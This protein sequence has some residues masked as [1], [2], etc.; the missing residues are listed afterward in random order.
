MN[1]T[2][3]IHNVSYGRP[4]SQFGTGNL[5]KGLEGHIIPVVIEHTHVIA[6]RCVFEFTSTAEAIKQLAVR[7]RKLEMILR[8]ME[9]VKVFFLLILSFSIFVFC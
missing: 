3:P 8:D 2:L 4:R 7:R 6:V 5:K 1:T 9:Q